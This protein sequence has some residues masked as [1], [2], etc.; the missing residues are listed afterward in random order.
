MPVDLSCLSFRLKYISFLALFFA[1]IVIHEADKLSTDAQYYLLWLMEKYKNC[2]KIFFC[3]SDA[4]KLQII[5]HLCKIVKLPPPSDSEVIYCIYFLIETDKSN[6][7][8]FS[9]GV[10]VRYILLK[11]IFRLLKFWSSSPSKNA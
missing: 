7:W 9:L 2:N 8:A 11:L 4:S 5:R 3:C 6:L 10:L 1:A